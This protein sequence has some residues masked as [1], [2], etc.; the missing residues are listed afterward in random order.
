[1]SAPIVVLIDELDRIEDE[2]I[3]I[4]AQL[5]RSVADF[6]GISYVL[7]YDA[8]RVMRALG[9]SEKLEHG[10]AYLEKIVQLQIP[11][12][13]LMDDEIH[14]LIEADL[15]PLCDEGLIP[16]GR[17]SI[18]RYTN[19]RALLVPRLIATP[20]DAKR[21]TGTF[22]I[23][24]RMLAGEVYW[25]DL[26]GFCALL[27]KAPLTVEQI[28]GDPDAVVDD[29]TSVDEMV[30][31][32]ADQKASVEALLDRMNPEREGGAGVR[33][34][35]ASLFPRLSE[36]RAGRRYDRREGTSI[37]KM[38]ALLTTL[39]LD[40]VPGYFSHNEVLDLFG[41]PEEEVT[42][43]LRLTY[44]QN[45]IGY[46]IVKLEDM[47]AELTTIPQ[48]SF[49]RG[50]AVFLE[51]PDDEYL[52]AYSP[53][54]EIVRSFAAIFFKITG[55]AARDLFLDLVSEGE[56]EITASLMRSHIFQHG[57]F[58]CTRSHNRD[59]VFLDGPE[60][61][62]IAREQ[63]AQHRDLH[64]A[65][66]FLWSIWQFNAVYTMINAGVWDEACQVRLT[67]FLTDPKAVDALTLMF[68]GAHYTTNR[69]MI[70][71][72]LDVDTYLRLVDQ[73]LTAVDLHE[74]VRL[75]LEKAKDPM[76]G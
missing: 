37:C 55:Q 6:P 47:N 60:A 44:D 26:L 27:V 16:G 52:A 18:E 19:L 48:Q 58:G 28:K 45:R 54:Y 42:A 29:P 67:A 70:A 34:L 72:F 22:S 32:A 24:L 5:V 33:R 49:W 20:R 59:G 2:E 15:D 7:A 66:R 68:F 21:L 38:R 23:L 17:T 13:V 10:R 50:V 74:S 39:R 65:G 76:F 12:P 64:L 69:E 25:I 41:R 35:L 1:M 62:A 31:R 8:E 61:E 40:L 9:G 30:G 46:L 75:A 73:R 4:V 3:R 36:D 56:V 11:L 57:L 14:R 51:K 53:M 71:K 43:F 63:A